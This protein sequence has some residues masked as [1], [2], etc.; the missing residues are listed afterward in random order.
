MA[1]PLSFTIDLISNSNHGQ[2]YKDL[3]ISYSQNLASKD[4]PIIFDLYHLAYSI[5]IPPYKLINVIRDRDHLYNTYKVRKKGGGYRWIMSPNKELKIIQNWILVNILNKIEIHDSS[6][7]F[8]KG[9]SIVLNAKN[10]INKELILN[11]DLYR[12][13]DTITEKRVYGLIKN[14][15]YTEKLSYDIARLLCVNAPKSYWKEIRKENRLKKKLI[16]TK[17]AILP[18]GAP[19]SPMVSNLISKRLDKAFTNYCSK[20]NIVYSRYADDLT[21]SG[22]REEMISLDVI[23]N[24]IRQQGFTINTKKTKY[25]SNHKKQTV[26]GITV[27]SGLHVDK[28][29]VRQINQELFFCL[30]YGYRNHLDYKATKGEPI[31]SGYKDWLLGK[32]CFIY[33]VEKKRGEKLFSIYNQIEWDI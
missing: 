22:K 4:L 27:N 23:K 19:T 6:N 14:L 16:N 21:F 5:G 28:K 20:C 2:D 13:F 30:K 24:I 3:L 15:G 31:K 26:T 10:H 17:P 11:I 8:V 18:Q 9:K 7:A 33:S 1:S 12:F 32:I 29:I 25:L